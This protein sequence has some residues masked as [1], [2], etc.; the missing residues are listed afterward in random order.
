ME[1]C[2][3]GIIER[4]EGKLKENG[5]KCKVYMYDEMEIG[6]IVD[7]ESEGFGIFEEIVMGM[8]DDDYGCF[9][10]KYNGRKLM[11]YDECKEELINKIK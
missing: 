1:K 8:Y 10:N 4:R 9:I 2:S 11:L 3:D 6:M 5:D 7:I